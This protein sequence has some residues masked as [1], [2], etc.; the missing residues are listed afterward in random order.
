MEFYRRFRCLPVGYYSS[1]LE[2]LEV[3]PSKKN[4]AACG[5]IGDDLMDIYV[6]LDE[7]LSLWD[8]GHRNEAVYHWQEGWLGI[9]GGDAADVVKILHCHISSEWALLEHWTI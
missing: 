7:G 1:V 6:D 2:P 9:W 8:N 5:E 4:A 3:P